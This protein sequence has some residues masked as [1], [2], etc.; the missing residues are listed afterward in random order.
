MLPDWDVESALAVMDRVGVAAAVLSV[1]SPGVYFGDEEAA[2]PLAR[3]VNDEAAAIAEA[4]PGRFGFAASL[5]IPHIPAAVTEVNR[6]LDDL[7]ADAVSLHTN[8]GGIYLGDERLNPILAALHEHEAVVLVH[9]TSPS[10]W[11]QVAFGRPRPMVEFIFDTTRAIFNLSLSGAFTEYPK[12]RWVVPH[13][14]GAIS[15][16]ADRVNRIAELIRPD[17]AIGVNVVTDLQRLYY[18]LAGVP[19]PRSLPA[20]LTLVAVDQI[21]YGSDYPF[22]NAESVYDSAGEIVAALDGCVDDPS[23]VLRKNAEALFPR[24]HSQL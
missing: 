23:L 4:H 19:L 15:V 7:S 6:A 21:V 14:G 18:D 13:T 8:Y 12:I 1:S 2:V 3:S 24:F 10:C 22:A 16:M 5:P 11:E 17:G 20:L 9:P